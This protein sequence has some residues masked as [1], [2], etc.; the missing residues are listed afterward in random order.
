[1]KDRMKILFICMI[2]A[3]GPAFCQKPVLLQQGVSINRIEY[4]ACT[5]AYFSPL[6]SG[7]RVPQNFVVKH[8]GF[9]C[10]QE[11]KLA[12][13]T[14]IPFKFRLGSISYCDWMEGKT[15]FKQ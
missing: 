11:W 4:N 12:S 14:K 8:Y 7:I 1:M 2:F 3:A 15:P 13:V 10:K 5:P 6:T 9:F